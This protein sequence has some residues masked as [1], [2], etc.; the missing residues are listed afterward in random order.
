LARNPR[1]LLSAAV[2][3]LAVVVLSFLVRWRQDQTSDLAD[4]GAAP[5]FALTDQL[6]RPVRSGDLAGRVVIASFIYTNCRDICPLL[7]VRMQ[8][9]Q[10][11]LRR[12]GLFGTRVQLL[13]FTVDPARDTPAVLR[14]YAERHQ[15]DP[16]A[17]RFLSGPTD[18]IVPLVVDGFRLGVEALPPEGDHAADGGGSVAAYDVTHSGRFVLIDRAGHIRAYYDGTEVDLERIVRDARALL[19]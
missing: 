18:T 16:D 7:S 6:E 12:E 5:A 14:A 13:S 11:R 15:A 4:F 2:L 10:E 1:F 3:G 8:Q 17:W 19:R 9:L